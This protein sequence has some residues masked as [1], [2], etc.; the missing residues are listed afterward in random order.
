[1]SVVGV[2]KVILKVLLQFSW[3][4]GVD[5]PQKR[6]ARPLVPSGITPNQLETT[7]LLGLN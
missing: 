5:P 3:R 6:R 1:M 2:G 4:R 7:D